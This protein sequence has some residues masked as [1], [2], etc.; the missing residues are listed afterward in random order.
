MPWRPWGSR[1]REGKLRP[2][3]EQSVR[4]RLVYMPLPLWLAHSPRVFQPEKG[5]CENQDA[6]VEAACFGF[7]GPATGHL[8]LGDRGGSA[9][10]RDRGLLGDTRRV[11][12]SKS[13][14]FMNSHEFQDAAWSLQQATD[15]P[16]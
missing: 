12:R 11:S 14:L 2:R 16:T 7:C 4:S 8:M 9:Q 15:N 6:Q 13:Y 1:A 5:S 10:P 3:V